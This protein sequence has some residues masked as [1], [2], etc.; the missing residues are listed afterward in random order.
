M[1]DLWRI[2]LHSSRCKRDIIPII[3]QAQN[4]LPLASKPSPHTVSRLAIPPRNNG[5]CVLFS[6]TRCHVS[7]NVYEV[8]RTATAFSSWHQCKADVLPL[9]LAARYS[10][11][12]AGLAHCAKEVSNPALSTFP[13]CYLVQ[14][15][16]ACLERWITE[17]QE[18]SP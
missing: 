18:R 17:K 2:E 16:P 9:S 7:R 5:R 4:L 14:V 12:L 13:S 8:Q 10:V 1:V 6:H 3:L 15:S 11:H